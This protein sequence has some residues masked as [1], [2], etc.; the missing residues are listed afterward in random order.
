MMRQ[1]NRNTVPAKTVCLRP[2]QAV[3]SFIRRNFAQPSGCVEE[4]AGKLHRRQ[5]LSGILKSV[6][7]AIGVKEIPFLISSINIRRKTRYY[8]LKFVRLAKKQPCIRKIISVVRMRRGVRQLLFNSLA[9]AA[10]SVF[11]VW[12]IRHLSHD[13]PVDGE[14]QKTVRE[15]PAAALSNAREELARMLKEKESRC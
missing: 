12:D 8:R 10:F 14:I 6:A 11:I 13:E 9:F 5:I 7:V 4:I 3:R 15:D 2:M 1:E